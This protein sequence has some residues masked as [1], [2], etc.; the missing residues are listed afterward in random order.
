MRGDHDDAVDA[1]IEGRLDRRIEPRAAVE[2][3]V[4]TGLTSHP[5]GAEEDRYRRR[6]QHMLVAQPPR[7]I[8]HERRVRHGRLL[9][10]LDEDDRTLGGG[11]RRHDRQRVDAAGLQVRPHRLP[12]QPLA[13][14]APQRRGIQERLEPHGVHPGELGRIT[15]QGP[16]RLIPQD[17]PDHPLLR[18]R[19]PAREKLV[20]RLARGPM[21]DRG[22]KRRRQ[23]AHA[24]THQ[25]GRTLAALLE[26]GQQLRQHPRFIRATRAAAGEHKTDRHFADDAAARVGRLISFAPSW[27]SSA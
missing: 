15:Q 10:R 14:G 16:R 2:E 13:H 9:T 7:Q 12:V 5:H 27:L 18:D 4:P 11:A 20:G 23:R 3:P 1:E 6:R 26:P 22:Q 19:A 25:H 24:R 21:R 8:V 17:R